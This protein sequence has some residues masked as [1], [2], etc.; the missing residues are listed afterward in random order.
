MEAGIKA[1][2]AVIV[3]SPGET[4]ETVQDTVDMMEEIMPDEAIV[5]IFTPYPGSPVWD[6]PEAFGMKI[7]TRDV[8]KY[9]AVGPDMTGNVVVER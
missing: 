3:G 6:D 8:S 9:A 4:W 7:L 2:A 5:C 1:K